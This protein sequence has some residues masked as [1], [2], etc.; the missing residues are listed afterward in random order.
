MKMLQLRP[1][2]AGVWLALVAGGVCFLTLFQVQDRATGNFKVRST[3]RAELRAP[4]SGFLQVVYGEEGVAVS[5]GTQVASL[6]IP[7]LASRL[8]QKKAEL[9]ETRAKLRLLEA[10][11]RPEELHEQREKAARATTWRELAVQDLDRKRR[12]LEEEIGR[13][14]ELIRQHQIELDTAQESLAQSRRLAENK[15]LS[16][17]LLREADRRFQIAQAQLKQAQAQK[18]ERIV[19]GVNEAEAELARREK[20]LA[21][22]QASLKLLLLGTRVEEIEAQKAQ[23]ARLQE[24][25]DYLDQLQNKVRVVSPIA[26]VIATPRLREKIG[27]YLKE[28]DL[29]C[30]IEDPESQEVEVVLQEQEVSR[31]SPGFTVELKARAL[32][33]QTFSGNVERVAPV[34][35]K[36]KHEPQSMVTVHCRIDSGAD[37]LRPGMSG[38]ARI[39]CGQRALGAVW[40]TRVARYLRTEFW[41]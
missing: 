13:L 36:E 3:N 41:W 21:D 4:V 40:A 25:A 34:A 1:V 5:A 26:G 14:T 8:T 15:A 10:G 12:A 24:E 35:V 22:A 39:E 16:L 17:E 2:R 11:P 31:V 29:I 28:G 38:Y 27:Q 19:L 20:D 37:G 18:R 7:D 30:E 23:L 32:P 33:F 6:E 9:A